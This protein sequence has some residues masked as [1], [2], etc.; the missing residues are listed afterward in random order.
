MNYLRISIFSDVVK[1]FQ[2]IGQNK[3]VAVN[4][5]DIF[6]ASVFNSGVARRAESEILFMTDK[7]NLVIAAVKLLAQCKRIIGRVVVNQNYFK[8]LERLIQN[9]VDAL[10]NITFN[11]VDGHDNRY[12]RIFRHVITSKIF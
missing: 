3:I 4:K 5:A 8:V 2:R 7:A 12:R 6:S 11:V 9:T 10:T 1:F